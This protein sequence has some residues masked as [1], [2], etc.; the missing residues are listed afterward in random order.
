MV[1]PNTVNNRVRA[2]RAFFAW[3]NRKGYTEDHVLKDLRPPKM[4]TKVIEPVTPE[5]IKRMFATMNPNTAMG[6]RNPALYSLMLD[7]GLRLSEVAHL[8]EVGVHIEERYVKVLGK[9]SKERIVAF[10]WACQRSLLHY[11]HHFRPE[12]AHLTAAATPT[13]VSRTQE[14]NILR[15]GCPTNGE[16]PEETVS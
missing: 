14:G 12:P 16:A 1:S 9:G 13:T 3:L 6:A 8:E 2:L 10:G 11:Y 15:C 4:V 5:E 7:T